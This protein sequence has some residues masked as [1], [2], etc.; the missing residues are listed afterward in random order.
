MLT[1]ATTALPKPYQPALP[2]RRWESDLRRVPVGDA[3]FAQVSDR[4]GGR[5]RCSPDFSYWQAGTRTQWNPHPNLDIGVELLYTK[6]DTAFK[7]AL[8]PGLNPGLPRTRSSSSKTRTSGRCSSA[9]SATSI[10]DR[11]IRTIVA[12]PSRPPA[13]NRRGFSVCH[14]LLRK[15]LAVQARPPGRRSWSVRYYICCEDR[16]TWRIPDRLHSDLAAGKL[17]LPQFASTRQKILS[18]F[19]RGAPD[20]PVLIDVRGSFYS[21]DPDG[22]LDLL[23]FSAAYA[24]SLEGSRPRRPQERVIDIGPPLRYRRRRFRTTR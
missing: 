24:S 14:P 12:Q 10:H 22:M 18:V 15:P 21:F 5:Q 1:S 8:I 20:G 7:G 23:P 11:L 13:G 9:G 19:F 3:G 4:P 6:L 17:A 2:G 16:L